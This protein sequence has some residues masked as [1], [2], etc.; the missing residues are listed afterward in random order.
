MKHPL[1]KDLDELM[2]ATAQG[3]DAMNDWLTDLQKRVGAPDGPELP[4]EITLEYSDGTTETLD[5][6]KPVGGQGRF[7]VF[8]NHKNPM[9]QTLIDLPPNDDWMDDE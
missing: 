1:D 7:P 5:T 2:K 6:T 4:D 9:P 3:P 8:Y